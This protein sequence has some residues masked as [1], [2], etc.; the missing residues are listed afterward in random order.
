MGIVEYGRYMEYWR[1]GRWNM[2]WE[3]GMG[4]GGYGIDV[5]GIWYGG[6]R[7]YGMGD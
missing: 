5:E 4:I 6:L 1:Y 2:G 7:E 3:Y